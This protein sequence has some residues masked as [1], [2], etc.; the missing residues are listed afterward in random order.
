MDVTKL[1]LTDPVLPPSPLADLNANRLCQKIADSEPA[2]VSDCSEDKQI[3][4]DFESLLLGKVL[5]EMK[6]TIGEW[7]FE[8]DGISKQVQGIFWLYLAQDIANK[9][10]FGLWKDIYEFMANSE[11]ANTTLDGT[12]PT[13]K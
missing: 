8:T 9:G 1:I 7:G 12:C 3:Y 13:V 11:R 5:D 10:G 6:N 4:K 2:K